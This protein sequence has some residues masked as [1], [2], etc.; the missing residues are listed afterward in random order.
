MKKAKAISEEKEEQSEPFSSLPLALPNKK[1]NGMILCTG[2]T[3]W[4]PFKRQ[5]SIPE[6][7]FACCIQNIL[8]MVQ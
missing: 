7:L 1:Q 3:L 6:K 4:L 2:T 8:M 5:S